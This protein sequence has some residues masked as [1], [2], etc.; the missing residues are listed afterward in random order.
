LALWLQS[1]STSRSASH[2]DHADALVEE[3][4]EHNSTSDRESSEDEE[5]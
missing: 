3:E 4:D 2:T 5:D 1:H